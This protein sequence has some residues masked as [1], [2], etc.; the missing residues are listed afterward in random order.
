MQLLRRSPQAAEDFGGPQLAPQW[1]ERGK[2]SALAAELRVQGTCVRIGSNQGRRGGGSRFA[3][4]FPIRKRTV[5]NAPPRLRPGE[6][7]TLQQAL[8]PGS[9]GGG[10]RAARPDEKQQIAAKRQRETELTRT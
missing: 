9:G 7:Q 4:S 1:R 3:R 10:V 5:G 8:T 2:T 6:E